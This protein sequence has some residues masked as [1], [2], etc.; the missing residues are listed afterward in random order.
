MKKYRYTIA[1]IAFFLLISSV[2]PV[3][4]QESAEETEIEN[5]TY[6]PLEGLPKDEQPQETVN[7]VL[8]QDWVIAEKQGLVTL[9]PQ[10]ASL[11]P[12]E[13][14]GMLGY[15][16]YTQSIIIN[17]NGYRIIIKNGGTLSLQEYN[18]NSEPL[19]IQG[20]H[21]ESLFY[22]E[23]GGIL[24]LNQ[25]LIESEGIAVEAEA[26]ADYRWACSNK[27][28]PEP[29]VKAPQG[30]VAV[31]LASGVR[32][33]PLKVYDNIVWSD[34]LPTEHLPEL[35]VF[36][37]VDGVIENLPRKLKVVWNTEQRKDELMERQ[38][39][40]LEG[41]FVDENNNPIE[42]RFVPSLPVYF[43]QRSP[44][45]ILS[46]DLIHNGSGTYH[47]EIQFEIPTDYERIGLEVSEDSG[48]NW[49]EIAS[50][51]NGIILRGGMAYA[52]VPDNQ[53][54]Q[55]RMVVEGG[56][57]AGSSQV[58]QLPEAETSKPDTEEDKGNGEDNS[59]NRD[60][61]D[62]NRGGGTAVNPPD[63]ELPFE[64]QDGAGEITTVTETDPESAGDEENSNS[65][66]SG[67]ETSRES[68]EIESET[69]ELEQSPKEDSVFEVEIQQQAQI[70]DLKQEAEELHKTEITEGNLDDL[71][72]KQNLSVGSQ[73]VAAVLGVAG[74]GMVTGIVCSPVLRSG[75]WRLIRRVFGR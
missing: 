3:F 41:C 27:E 45:K 5:I 48:Q 40:I 51:E 21:P 22:V 1:I 50:L 62:G 35:S 46:A 10:F 73:A 72:E 60:E 4:A 55:Y 71:S 20:E 15:P 43:L 58:V 53:I 17:T 31:E 68:T 26:G 9:S 56:P 29:A 28:Y 74:C 23:S 34:S 33:E 69:E 47:V 14:E 49:E 19:R 63:R 18:D 25:V 30:L 36:C 70:E 75:I 39:C 32:M 37:S 42:S 38:D 16:G 6:N 54:R 52:V 59:N 64:S 11:K 2:V 44:I 57:N 12:A 66:E 8:S 13:I 67:L 24:S 61:V 7:I 65:I